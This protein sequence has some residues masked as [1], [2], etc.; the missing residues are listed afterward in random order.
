MLGITKSR[1]GI[2]VV[3]SGDRF[4]RVAALVLRR[5]VLDSARPEAGCNA[6][7]LEHGINKLAKG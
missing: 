5:K 4:S 2:L 3:C 7:A 1:N 6:F